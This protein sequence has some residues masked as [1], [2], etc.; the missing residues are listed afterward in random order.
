MITITITDTLQQQGAQAATNLFNQANPDQYLTAEQYC[1]MVM[2][3]ACASYADQFKVGIIS[4][5]AFV[6]R[7]LPAEYAAIEAAGATDPIVAGFMARV[8]ESTEVVLYA[9]EVVDGLG[10]LVAQELLTQER[11]DAILAYSVPINPAPPAPPPEPEPEPTP[12]PE[13]EPTPEPTPEE[14]QP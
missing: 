5:G 9:P 13:P 14:P 3:G 1:Q 10:Y 2:S 12:E 4:S 11:A 6:L 7:F 8:I